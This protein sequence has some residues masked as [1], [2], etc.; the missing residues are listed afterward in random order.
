[1]NEGTIKRIVFVCSYPPRQCGIATFSHDLLSNLKLLLPEVLFTVCAVNDSKSTSYAYP[2]EVALQIDQ[3]DEQ[4]YTQAAELI[5]K[6]A[7]ET[8]VIVQHEYG[9][10]GGS[11]GEYLVSLLKALRCPAMVTLH[12]VIAKPNPKMRSVT[13]QIIANCDKLITLTDSSCALFASL[14]PSAKNKVTRIMHG[15]HPLLYK[16][17]TESKA[18]YKLENRK[19]LL[20]FGLLSRNKGI[21]YVINALPQIKEQIPDIIYLVVGGTHPGVIRTEGEAY[22][23]SLIE[24]VKN[25][26]LKKNVRFVPKFLPLGDILRYI[27]SADIYIA[28]SLDPQQAV[29]GTMSYALGSG[30]SV[31]AT[32]FAQANEIVRKDV[33]RVVPIRDSAAI[34]SAVIELFSKPKLLRTMNHAA[35]SETRSM[36]WSNT[37]DNYADS[38]ADIAKLRS[39]DLIRWPI[40][41]WNH[42]ETLTD[43]FG[44]L[45]FSDKRKPDYKSGYTL[46]DNS[47]ALQTVQRTYEVGVLPKD[48]Y[49]ELAKKY[50]QIMETCLTQS[51]VANY[52]EAGTKLPTSQNLKENLNDSMARA[53]YS[54]QTIKHIGPKVMRDEATKLLSLLPT[55]LFRTPYIRTL[56]Q[57]LLGA[58]FAAQY[59][60]VKMRKIVN[61]LADTLVQAYDQNSTPG[62][63]WFDKSMTYANGQ[64]CASL[65]EASRATG[66][67]VYRQIGLKSLDFLCK[68]C[69][70]GEVYTPIGQ[71][72]WRNRDDGSRA[73]FDQQPED[74]FSTMQALE[75]AYS[76][77]GDKRYIILATKVFSWF[78]GNN[79][80]GNRLYD[81]KNGGCHDGLKPDG[82]NQNEGAESTISYL[83]ARLIMERLKNVPE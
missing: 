46:D 55:D 57:M 29:S 44:M 19:V 35:Y 48:R 61:D 26:S 68:T 67:E 47:R 9:V 38:L 32:N 82:V 76:L 33:G 16:T 54:L 51:P 17:P 70:M 75:S 39:M 59:G 63:K 18:K 15:I 22:R 60:D 13:K 5:N 77:T 7:E 43:E 30:R 52:L 71:D 74:A 69:F 11:S 24:L 50:L 1:M 3:D 53:F 25:L 56:A 31:V 41:R 14:Y 28:T 20:T 21:E 6:H 79:L 73:L 78:M 10:Y 58:S 36:L 8:I 80:V 40:L 12:T 66:S 49:D 81:D 2:K 27:Q 62:W 83:N 23:E 34:A 37:A 72:G 65:I 64:L 4:S 45:Q 42:F